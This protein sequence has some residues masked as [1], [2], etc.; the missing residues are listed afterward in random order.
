MMGGSMIHPMQG[1]PNQMMGVNPM[2]NQQMMHQPM[3]NQSMMGHMPQQMMGVNPM[4]HQSAMHHPM[5]ATQPVM[6]HYPVQQN[7]Q[8]GP[9]T[10]IHQQVNQVVERAVM[11]ERPIHYQTVERQVQPQIYEKPVIVEK[12]YPVEHVQRQYV[13]VPHVVE[14]P[15]TVEKNIVLEK[16]V[17]YD[18]YTTRKEMPTRIVGERMTGAVYGGTPMMS[19]MPQAH[20]NHASFYP[21]YASHAQEMD[22]YR[23]G[24]HNYRSGMH[25]IT[26]G[27]DHLRTGV[28]HNP[29][30]SRQNH[31]SYWK[32][33]Y[34]T[35]LDYLREKVYSYD[36][37]KD[38]N[39]LG[40]YNDHR[41][42]DYPY[43]RK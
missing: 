7:M 5:M 25:N 33:K 9:P 29:Y 21:G 40:R 27:M 17:V 30:M 15:I 41:V 34:P 11:V 39:R 6:S 2:M 42:W 13:N 26:T 10:A 31:D 23:H 36:Y 14:K 16:P 43:L 35:H 24:M 20:I 4:M 22:H 18:H 19:T 3:M 38:T 1:M 12:P 37:L 32:D 28:A 8:M